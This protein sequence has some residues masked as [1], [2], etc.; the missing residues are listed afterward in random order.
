MVIDRGGE[1]GCGGE[2]SC[3]SL[4]FLSLLALSGTGKPFLSSR[5]GG[6]LKLLFLFTE[7]RVVSVSLRG[8]RRGSLGAK[9]AF[10]LLFL[11]GPRLEGDVVQE[12]GG[13]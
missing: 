12:G 4:F 7:K 5:R 6:A 11:S 2:T 9:K 1:M 8:V 10:P 3:L 13:W